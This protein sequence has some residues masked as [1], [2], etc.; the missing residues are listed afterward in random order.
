VEKIK[1]F[2]ASNKLSD[3]MLDEVIEKLKLWGALPV[4]EK[5]LI[6]FVKSN[7]NQEI[8]IGFTSG[9]VEERIRTLQTSH[10]YQIEL[11]ATI[12]GDMKFE[13]SL[14][15]RFKEYRLQGEWFFPHPELIDYINKIK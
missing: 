10:P 8:K 9:Q 3:F 14:H 11:L 5:G 12:S 1:N 15:E 2:I 4:K 7:K 13:R 6:Y